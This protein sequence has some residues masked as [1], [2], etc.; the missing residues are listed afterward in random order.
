[1]A[2]LCRRCSSCDPYW[3]N[4]VRVPCARVLAIALTAA[5]LS[6]LNLGRIAQSENC[7]SRLLEV[8]RRGQHYFVEP[9]PAA[10]PPW[11]QWLGATVATTPGR[12]ARQ[13]K[14]LLAALVAAGIKGHGHLAALLTA[15]LF[16]AIAFCPLCWLVLE[17]CLSRR[18]NPR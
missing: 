2:D 5:V 16:S 17:W 13:P 12:S 1:M 18:S 14:R 11:Y 9:S 7:Q 8:L 3:R 6:A 4:A 15:K 10:R